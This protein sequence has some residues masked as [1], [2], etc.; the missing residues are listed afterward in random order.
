MPIG[1]A[2]R[3]GHHVR[4]RTQLAFPDSAESGHISGGAG[5]LGACV[6]IKPTFTFW[7]F[8]AL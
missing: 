8:I 3:G 6:L 5:Q 2:S 1:W 4:M 7:V